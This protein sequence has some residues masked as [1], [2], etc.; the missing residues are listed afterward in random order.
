MKLAPIGPQQVTLLI[1]MIEYRVNSVG[2][3]MM[4]L[5]G[6]VF[7]NGARFIEPDIDSASNGILHI[8]D[9]I[10]LEQ[11]LTSNAY[12]FITQASTTESTT[13]VSHSCCCLSHFLSH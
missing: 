3:Y 2:K 7:I 12:N 1:K 5:Q 10:L 4:N 9:H 11:T 6:E 8:I 13:Y